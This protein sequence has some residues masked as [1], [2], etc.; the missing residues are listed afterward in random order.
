MHLSCKQDFPGSN[1]GG[2]LWAHMF[3]S[4]EFDLQLNWM[5]ATPIVSMDVWGNGSL[6]R[7][8]R[9]DEGSIPSTSISPIF[10]R[11]RILDLDSSNLGS[12]PSRVM[13]QWSNGYDGR[14]SIF[15]PEFDSRLR[16][17]SSHKIM[18]M[19]YLMVEVVYWLLHPTVTREK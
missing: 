1:P 7:L 13:P 2:S 9:V 5:G 18:W 3:R 14:L 15:K 19:R 4:G 17:V 10:Q 8:R 12:N 11:S 16:R 6:T